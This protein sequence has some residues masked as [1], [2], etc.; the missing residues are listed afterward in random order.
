MTT[1]EFDQL[2]AARTAQRL[3]HVEMIAARA[4]ERFRE[5][6]RVGADAVDLPRQ[7]IDGLDQAGIA[8]ETEQRLVKSQIAVEHGQHLALLDGGSMLALQLLQPLDVG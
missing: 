3:D 2:V 6:I 4:V 8:A 7:E 1:V 5:R